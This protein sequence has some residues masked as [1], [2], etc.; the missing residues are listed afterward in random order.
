MHILHKWMLDFSEIAVIMYMLFLEHF[1]NRSFR[2]FLYPPFL[3]DKCFY[4]TCNCAQCTHS[5]RFC[6]LPSWANYLAHQYT[7][8][9]IVQHFTAFGSIHEFLNSD[10]MLFSAS[11]WVFYYIYLSNYVSSFHFISDDPHCLGF[12]RFLKIIIFRFR[13]DSNHV[14][15]LE[16][17]NP[18]LCAELS[19]SGT[20]LTRNCIVYSLELPVFSLYYHF[21]IQNVSN[22]CKSLVKSALEHLKHVW[23][24][25]LL[26]KS[27]CR[28]KSLLHQLLDMIKGNGLRNP[29][30][31]SHACKDL[32]Q[33]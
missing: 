33:I 25:G 12:V 3:G 30:E 15:L 26:Q 4:W 2:I 21:R 1:L 32:L 5:W 23:R 20:G 13:M 24:K 9:A 17:S 14:S 22:N 28:I 19:P 7:K 10:K 29:V 8:C 11:S 6:S 18:S 31:F 16:L 27:S